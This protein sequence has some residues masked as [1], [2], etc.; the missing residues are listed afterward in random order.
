MNSLSLLMERTLYFHLSK[1]MSVADG[2]CVPHNHGSSGCST[3][4]GDGLH[5]PRKK[6]TVLAIFPS[7]RPNL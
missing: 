6:I 7:V 2:W 3:G 4:K 1:T 5:W